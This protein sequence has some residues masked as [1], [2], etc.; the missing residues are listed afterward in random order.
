MK[1]VFGPRRSAWGSP[2]DPEGW[3]VGSHL[4][5]VIRSTGEECYGKYAGIEWTLDGAK[6]S[7]LP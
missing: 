5:L 4:H 2:A 3:L 7:S 1:G 6:I